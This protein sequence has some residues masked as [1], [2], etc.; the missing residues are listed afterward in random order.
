V[1]GLLIFTV[2]MLA[3]CVF[4]IYFLFA[5]WCDMHKQSVRSRVEIR[6]LPNRE[7]SKNKL[8]RMYDVESLYTRIETGSERRRSTI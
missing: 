1:I 8:L 4:L 7:R 2:M 5:L 3:G 6:E